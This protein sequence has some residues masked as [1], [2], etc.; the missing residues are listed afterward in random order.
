MKPPLFSV[1]AL[2]GTPT[3]LIC[4]PVA[5]H[6]PSRFHLLQNDHRFWFRGWQ[7]G[8]PPPGH[9][10]RIDEK[11]NVENRFSPHPS[12][13]IKP[14]HI[15]V[16]YRFVILTSGPLREWVCTLHCSAYALFSVVFRRLSCCRLPKCSVCSDW[17]TGQLFWDWSVAESVCRKMSRPLPRYFPISCRHHRTPR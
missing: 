11:I 16:V 14:V 8:N 12:L 9:T 10:W 7:C 4:F 17:S 13:P 6:L 2:K 5:A 3:I 15:L 1:H